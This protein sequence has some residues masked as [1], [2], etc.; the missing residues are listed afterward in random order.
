MKVWVQWASSGSPA[1]AAAMSAAAGAKRRMLQ[2]RN[3]SQISRPSAMSMPAAS[4]DPSQS[5]P[6]KSSMSS[7]ERTPVSAAWAVRNSSAERR[8]SSR[9]MVR[10]FPLGVELGGSAKIGH[11]RAR[12][13]VDTIWAH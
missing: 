11:R 4:P 9:S 1:A 13:A 6:T 2:L 10:N 12:N 8:P 3:D 5:W 7:V